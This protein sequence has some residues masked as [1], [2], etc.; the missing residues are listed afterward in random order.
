LIPIAEAGV[1]SQGEEA[2]VR[3]WES[4]DR[5]EVSQARE[6]SEA[7]KVLPEE[8]WTLLGKAQGLHSQP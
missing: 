5:Q 3:L 6:Y 1:P 4:E 7:D 2:K 8:R